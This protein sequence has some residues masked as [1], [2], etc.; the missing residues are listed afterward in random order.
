MAEAVAVPFVESE[1]IVK[2]ALDTMLGMR[3]FSSW[4]SERFETSILVK[5]LVL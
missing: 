1:D 2:F 4:R 3:R 5:S